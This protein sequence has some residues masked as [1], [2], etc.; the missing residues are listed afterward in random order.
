[1]FTIILA[2]FTVLLI[3]RLIV[4]IE[5]GEFK[6]AVFMALAAAATGTLFYVRIMAPE[7][8]TPEKT[9]AIEKRK[10]EIE[11]AKTP[12]VFSQTSDGCTVY[13]F[14]DNG[15]NHYFTRCE[16]HVS[17]DTTCRSG[18]STK[19]EQ[20]QTL[21]NNTNDE[22]LSTCVAIHPESKGES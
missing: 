20:I 1:M 14:T 13:K 4:A 9:A 16:Q 5:Y 21:Q 2:I 6:I 11:E 8:I 18:K 7:E 19:V 22:T 12:K 10:A 3:I 15:Y 17:T